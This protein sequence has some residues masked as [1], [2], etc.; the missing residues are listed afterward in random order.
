MSF[1]DSNSA[2]ETA[3]TAGASRRTPDLIRMDDPFSQDLGLAAAPT[4]SARNLLAEAVHALRRRW[5]AAFVAGVVVGSIAF[6]AAWFS[7]TPQVTATAVLQVSADKSNVLAASQNIE[8]AAGFDVYKK[9]QR[10][11][12]RSPIVLRSVLQHNSISG[13]PLVLQQSDPLAWLQDCVRVTY[14]DEAEI[15]NI[16]VRCDDQRTAERL[17]DTIVEVYLNEVVYAERQ[18]KSNRITHLS[19]AVTETEASL[20]KK[21]DELRTLADTMGTGDSQALTLAQKNTVEL[22]SALSKQL[23][24]V[25]FDLKRAQR[26][27]QIGAGAAPAQPDASVGV[28]DEEMEAAAAGDLII[29]AAKAQMDRRQAQIDDARKSMF[30]PAE[31]EFV[32][33]CQ[34]SIER[35]RKR[36]EDR[37]VA[38]RKELLFKKKNQALAVGQAWAMSA[39]ELASQKTDLAAQLALLRKEAEKFGRSSVD[40][41]LMRA[42]IKALDD[43]RDRIQKEVQ[44]ANIEFASLKSRVVKLSDATTPHNAEQAR[45]VTLSA[46]AGGMGSFAACALVVA[47]ELRRRRLNTT[48]EIA[49]AIRLPLLGTMPRAPRLLD[50]TRPGSQLKEAIDGIVARLVFSSS[51]DSQQVVLV[52]SAAAGEGKTTVAV[53]LATS[54][55]AMGRRTVLVDFDLRRPTLH[56]MFD[57]DLV[58]GVGGILAGQV[59]PLDAIVPTSVE[60]LF[61]LPAGAWGGRGISGRDDDLVK[62]ILGEL[63]AAFV[64]VVIDAGPVLPIVDTRV[65]ARH[66]DGVIISLLRDVSEIPKVNSACELLRSF[67]VR[68]L[69][70]VMIGAPGEVYY[71]R[72]IAEVQDSA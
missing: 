41:E 6:T 49:E 37:K 55:A 29:G 62:R 16:S 47:W 38:L 15:M 22:Y 44:E 2:T 4:P 3:S 7:V 40:V 19:N 24:Q 30:G 64:H 17:V 58:P 25:E 32:A 53:N 61:L 63:R 26:A 34:A 28:S 70:A 21:R 52:T 72:T 51:D 68:I 46:S 5:L 43:L 48:R 66:A 13:L 11:L 71:S 54:F 12:L 69:G 14:P 39:E 56:N 23:N 42:D 33:Q 31:T 45:R 10:Q 35:I 65:L 57:V 59:E 50:A 60:N 18:E 36:G 1:A 9:T 67:D 20:R 27:R 8:A